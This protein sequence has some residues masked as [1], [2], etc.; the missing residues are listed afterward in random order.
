MTRKFLT[1][2]V[3]SSGFVMALGLNCLP[4]IGTS[5]AGLFGNLGLGNLTG[6][7]GG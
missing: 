2:A 3:L 6:L 5:F 1:L 7:L 4:N